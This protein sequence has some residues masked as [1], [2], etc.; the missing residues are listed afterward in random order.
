MAKEKVKVE[1]DE[2]VH[3]EELRKKIKEAS[4]HKLKISG[5][6]VLIADL[7]TAAKEDLGVE[8]KTF[9]QLLALYHKDT[10]D[11]FEEEKDKVVELYDS[12]FTK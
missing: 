2:A 10:R 6:Q 12:V 5:Y 8:S 11:Q 7:R 9:N 1:F 4:D 3:G